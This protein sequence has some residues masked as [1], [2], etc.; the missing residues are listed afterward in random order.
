VWPPGSIGD[1]GKLTA[2]DLRPGTYS[3]QEADPAPDFDLQAIA[4][5]DQNSSGDVRTRAAVIRVEPGESVRCVFTNKKRPAV[6]PNRP[7]TCTATAGPDLLWPP[8]HKYRLVDIGGASDPDDDRVTLRITGVTQDEPLNG[9][10]DGNTAPDAKRAAAAHQV[11]VRAE[12]S[13]RGDGRVYR[14][15]LTG[16]DG[17]GGTCVG[18]ATVGVPHDQG[19]GKTP[20]DSAPPSYNSFG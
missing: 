20:V 13:G 4:C 12:R 19:H 11:Y 6:P 9:L 5:S 16:S 3:A 17:K 2:A 7:P 10:G 15:V 1:G 18:T 8:N 14:I